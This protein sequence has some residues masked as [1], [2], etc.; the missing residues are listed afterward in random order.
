M[1]IVFKAP[2]ILS[3]LA[4]SAFSIIGLE[5]SRAGNK[6]I[7]VYDRCKLMKIT[8]GNGIFKVKIKNTGQLGDPVGA[9]KIVDGKPKITLKKKKKSKKANTTPSGNKASKKASNN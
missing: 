8:D 5:P 2:I 3:L 9:Y 7:E 1:K 4:V 6:L